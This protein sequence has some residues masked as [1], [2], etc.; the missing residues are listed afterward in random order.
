MAEVAI[1]SSLRTSAEG[2]SFPG[3]DTPHTSV[4]W[5]WGLIVAGMVVLTIILRA[6]Y[7][8]VRASLWTIGLPNRIAMATLGIVG[9]AACVRTWT[10][11]G[12]IR[13][14]VTHL[15]LVGFLMLHGPFL[16][17]TMDVILNL[18][19]RGARL[20]RHWAERLLAG[21]RRVMHVA[22]GQ[23]GV[24]VDQ[25]NRDLELGTRQQPGTPELYFDCV[26]DWI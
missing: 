19:D 18:R 20:V 2:L 23:G 10:L 8:G 5:V 12:E 24:A 15:I 7:W 26:G 16:N 11:L 13:T 14:Q 25:P 17:A 22:S 21:L 1:N 3:E 6:C 4:N 9:F